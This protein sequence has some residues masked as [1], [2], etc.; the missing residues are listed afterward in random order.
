MKTRIQLIQSKSMTF[1]IQHITLKIIIMKKITSVR[2][3]TL[4]AFL[5]TSLALY[6]QTDQ[7][8]DY[9]VSL[10]FEIKENRNHTHSNY[11]KQQG[12]TYP[13]WLYT[14]NKTNEIEFW[15][16]N[17][18]KRLVT[19]SGSNNSLIF[20]KTYEDG[21]VVLDTVRN[22]LH[23]G[24]IEVQR[25]FLGIRKFFA[26]FRAKRSLR[27]LNLEGNLPEG[28]MSF[29][30]TNRRGLKCGVQIAKNDSKVKI[31]LRKKDKAIEVLVDGNLKKGWNNFEW[32][33]G[34][35]KKGDYT[36]IFTVDDHT[37][38]QNVEI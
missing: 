3:F 25:D 1:F 9:K 5:F 31:E 27:K 11:F 19:N 38:S 24:D 2:R 29:V 23:T 37:M 16:N 7:S 36:L 8:L 10:D 28:C 33:R 20:T 32:K 13:Q 12:E 35:Y 30:S 21:N 15:K 26:G 6:S 34:Q 4:M 18:P 17:G 22:S 14:L